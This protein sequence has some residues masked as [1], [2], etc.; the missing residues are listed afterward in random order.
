M[1]TEQPLA[2]IESVALREVWPNEASNFTPWLAEHITEL[3]EALAAR[4][5]II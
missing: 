2:N 5:R 1:T 3:G 4:P